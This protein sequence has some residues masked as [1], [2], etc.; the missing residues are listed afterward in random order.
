MAFNIQQGRALQS[1]LISIPLL[2]I[3]SGT[4][5]PY[6]GSICSSYISKDGRVFIP[7][8][9]SQKH[10]EENIVRAALIL[11]GYMHPSCKNSLVKALCYNLF[12]P[13]QTGKHPRPRLLCKDECEVL[14][15]RTCSKEFRLLRKRLGSLADETVPNCSVLSFDSGDCLVIGE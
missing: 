9:K 2:F 8:L 14:Q 10:L 15:A 5:K 1:L 11:T 4:C 3:Y 12:P 13:C 6:S 7:H